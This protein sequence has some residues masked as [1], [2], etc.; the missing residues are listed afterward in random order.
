M[1]RKTVTINGTLYDALSGL[2]LKRTITV[3]DE[4]SKYAG[5]SAPSV[6]SHT[7][8]SSTQKSATLQRQFVK[9]RPTETTTHSSV[10]SI[11]NRSSQMTRTTP[12]TPRHPAVARFAANPKT[13]SS[14]VKTTSAHNTSATSNHSS[15]IAAGSHPIV[16]KADSHV[17]ALKTKSLQQSTPVVHASAKTI[18]NSHIKRA[19]ENAPSH[20]KNHKQVK[21]P[22]RR[23]SNV[24]RFSSLGLGALLFGAYATYLTMPNLSVRYAA[25]QSGI[26]AQYPSYHP[27]GYSRGQLAFNDSAVRL[28]F[29]SNAGPQDFVLTQTNSNWD[30][31]A[32]K[33]QYAAKQWSGDVDTITE[34]GLTIYRH[35]GEAAWVNGGILYTIS[36]DASLSPSQIRNI[37]TSL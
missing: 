21:Q 16:S 36:G 32:V 25:A 24:M 1:T 20:T 28:N 35:G 17:Y 13:N 10:S 22:R 8:H 14:S 31:S 2:P 18:K 5:R 15:D 4:P 26:S 9:R 3:H 29:K 6:Q 19:L 30:S 34:Q 37:A 33:E 11:H 7:V 27:D 12:V 23:F